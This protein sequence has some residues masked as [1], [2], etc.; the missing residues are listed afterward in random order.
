MIYIGRLY[1][2]CLNKSSMSSTSIED[3]GYTPPDFLEKVPVTLSSCSGGLRLSLHKQPS[4]PHPQSAN[5]AHWAIYP[6]RLWCKLA[7]LDPLH[8]SSSVLTHLLRIRGYPQRNLRYFTM[9]SWRAQ[10]PKWR[11]LK[12]GRNL[13][14][15]ST[16]PLTMTG[17][18][19]SSELWKKSRGSRLI[20]SWLKTAT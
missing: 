8:P 17:S 1:F 15:H 6:H 4:N 7:S 20:K 19:S 18:S 2:N 14:S 16:T 11:Q 3:Q 12:S 5:S 13:R 9:P 10:S